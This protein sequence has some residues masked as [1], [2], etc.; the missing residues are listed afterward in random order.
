MECLSKGF[1][2]SVASLDWVRATDALRREQHVPV[3]LTVRQALFQVEGRVAERLL[4]VRADEARRMPLLLER[5]QTVL[6]FFHYLQGGKFL[7]LTETIG[8]VHLAHRGAI[9]LSKQPSQYFL[10]PSSTNPHSSRRRP[11]DGFAQT[12]CSGHHA[13]PVAKTKAP[14]Q[15]FWHY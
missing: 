6:S 13:S 11:Q 15:V 3:L 10:P 1:D 9:W 14:L 7:E 5:V 4:A 12:K 2:P 8:L